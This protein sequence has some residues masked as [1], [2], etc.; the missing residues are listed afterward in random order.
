MWLVLEYDSGG[1][2]RKWQYH[3]DVDN[4]DAG[5]S[6]ALINLNPGATSGNEAVLMGGGGAYSK[7]D[8]W[9]VTLNKIDATDGSV[10]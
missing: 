7:N 4:G 10:K 9:V 3:S 1:F 8:E 6:A 2:T 5:T